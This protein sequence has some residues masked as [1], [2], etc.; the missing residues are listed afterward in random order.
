MNFIKN[1]KIF[2]KNT[3]NR[4]VLLSAERYSFLGV[5][6]D[7]A[8]VADGAGAYMP[9][10]GGGNAVFCHE[11][12]IKDGIFLKTHGIGDDGDGARGGKQKLAGFVEAIVEKITMGR[13]SVSGA[14]HVDDL[15]F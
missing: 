8:V 12:A 7:L 4:S 5:F 3:E 15:V 13:F 1:Q 6:V 2:R 10:I 9:V 14:E 11:R